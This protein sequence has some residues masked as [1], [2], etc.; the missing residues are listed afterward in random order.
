MKSYHT[1]LEIL[2]QNSF[3]YV[4]ECSCC[5]EIQFS[6]GNIVSHMNENG[7]SNLYNAMLKLEKDIDERIVNMPNGEK[8]L[9][10]TPADQMVLSLSRDEFDKTMDLFKQASL[11]L[12]VKQLLDQ[13][14]I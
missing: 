1:N 12:E 5:G 8:V 13:E 10:R 9:L 14:E 4:G 7:F 3:G 2:H 6:I 11:M